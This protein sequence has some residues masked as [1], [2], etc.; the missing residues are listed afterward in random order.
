VL[1]QPL[2]IPIL[3][4][5]ASAMWQQFFKRENATDRELVVVLNDG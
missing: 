2:R 5:K 1:S 3:I 4:N